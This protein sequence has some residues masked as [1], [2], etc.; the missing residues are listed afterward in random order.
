[1]AK[2]WIC[3]SCGNRDRFVAYGSIPVRCVVGPDGHAIIDSEPLYDSHPDADWPEY[4][5]DCGSENIEAVE[6][7]EL[8][9]DNNEQ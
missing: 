3:R 5:D 2:V 8:D 4:C 6:E 9:D 1:M 7:E